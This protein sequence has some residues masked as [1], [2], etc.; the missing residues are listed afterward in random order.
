MLKAKDGTVEFAGIWEK[1]HNPDFNYGGF[2]AIKSQ[3]GLNSY[4]LSIKE[5]AF[6]PMTC[7][8]DAA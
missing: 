5:A 4:K 6:I 1:V 3:A 2:A 7:H 8:L